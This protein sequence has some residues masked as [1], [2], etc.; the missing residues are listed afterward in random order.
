MHQ[1]QLKEVSFLSLT[2]NYETI[3]ERL[4][5]TSLKLSKAAQGKIS[6]LKTFQFCL[7]SLLHCLEPSYQH[8]HSNVKGKGLELVISAALLKSI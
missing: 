1:T 3:S 2:G 7:S 8:F 6:S 5:C 4:L